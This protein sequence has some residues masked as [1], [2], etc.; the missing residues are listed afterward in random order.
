MTDAAPSPDAPHALW[1]DAF[2]LAAACLMVSLGVVFYA[3]AT[4]LFGGSAGL[5]LL[6]TY[7]TDW[8]FWATF[9][10]VNLPFY[11]LAALRMGAGFTLRTFAAV[12]LVAALTRLQTDWV[13][14]EKVNA[15]YAC[16]IG[17]VLTGTGLLILFR[18][19]AGL[20]GVAVLALHLQERLGWRAGWTQLA[21]DLAILAAAAF[22]LPPDRL[23][24]SVLGA[25]IVNLTLAVNHRPGRYR[26]YS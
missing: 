8:P 12:S 23:A 20:G 9:S 19:R 26:G 11:A 5:G 3:K 24:Y 2:A 18:H 25:V 16:V 10:L 14:L 17:G 4:L 7:A 6:L 1:E 21:I 13:S 22:V 15:L